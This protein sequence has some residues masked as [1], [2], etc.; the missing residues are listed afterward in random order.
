L[1]PAFDLNPD[2][3]TNVADVQNIVKQALG[4]SPAVN[5]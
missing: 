5:I 1:F 2:E 3:T 4:V